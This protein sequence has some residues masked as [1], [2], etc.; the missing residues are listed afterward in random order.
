[1]E[2]S[3]I[4]TKSFILA[5]C[6]LC[7]LGCAQAFDT[8]KKFPV[9]EM[10]PATKTLPAITVPTDQVKEKIEEK[11]I[12]PA[13][14]KSNETTKQGK[15]TNAPISNVK[16]K[17][18]ILIKQNSKGVVETEVKPVTAPVTNPLAVPVSAP[19]A[20][21]TKL[22][23]KASDLN[24][25]SSNTP[26]SSIIK[27]A[28]KELSLPAKKEVKP[29]KDESVQK[30]EGTIFDRFEVKENLKINKTSK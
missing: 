30:Q 7:S 13:A 24:Q 23:L 22:P 14:N 26:A 4:K 6:L 28:N 18:E 9:K 15:Q 16:N 10:K 17:E 27:P 2:K 20:K 12:T 11:V 19:V 5:T 29:A 3:S 21:P 25:E 1:M 8:E